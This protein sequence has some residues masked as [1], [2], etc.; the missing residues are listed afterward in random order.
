MSIFNKI[1][2][3]GFRRILNLEME[4][5]PL[6]VMIGPNGSGK[7]SLL[8]VL[9][10]ISSSAAGRLNDRLSDLTGLQ[11]VLTI[12]HAKELAVQL[13]MPVRENALLDYDL[14]IEPSGISYRIKHETLVQKQNSPPH[15]YRYIESHYDDIRYFNIE[16]ES[17]TRPTWQHNPVESSLS[18]VPRMFT[19]PEMFRLNLSSLSYYHSLN[20]GSRDPVRLPQPLKPSMLPGENGEELVSCLFSMRE[21]DRDRFETLT[22]TLRS[23][24]NGFER[25]DFPPVAA[26]TLAM[27]WKDR[28]FKSPMFMH[29]L[30][31][32]MLRFLWLV[33]LLYSPG[34]AQVTLIDEPEVSLHPELLSILVDVMR[35]VSQE[36]Q[37]VVATHS[38]R[39]VRFLRPE[40]VVV[41]DIDE[42]GAVCATWAD[43]LNLDEWLQDYTLD[44]VWRLGRMGGRA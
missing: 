24:F 11:S 3:K 41:V 31:E 40:E 32:G 14:I 30:S 1:S 2:V 13:S 44:E 7:T 35:E 42:D 28:H 33:T 23:A 12:G 5:R 19:E 21:S 6:T 34:L 22:D 10:L 26:G 17:F 38:D 4:L 15:S 8:D 9:S 36:K 43:S 16:D 18:Q 29:Q 25:L 39:L 27:T 37:I 20:V